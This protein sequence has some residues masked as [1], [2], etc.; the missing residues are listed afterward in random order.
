VVV[1][2]LIYRFNSSSNL[3]LD[4]NNIK[5]TLVTITNKTRT[6]TI[7]IEEVTTTII[8][9]DIITIIIDGTTTIIMGTITGMEATDIETIIGI[10]KCK[11]FKG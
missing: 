7:I 5:G 11:R 8:T 3:Q 2:C 10:S 4:N 1:I 6:G 9:T